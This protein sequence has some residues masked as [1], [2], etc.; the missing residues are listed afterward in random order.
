VFGPNTTFLAGTQLAG[1]VIGIRGGLPS[2]FVGFSHDLFVE[3]PVYKPGGFTTSRVTVGV[4]APAQFWRAVG[5]CEVS[6]SRVQR[7][8]D[9]TPVWTSNKSLAL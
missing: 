5:K 6:P 9:N 8:I 7:S 2:R 1:A 4:Q 3:T